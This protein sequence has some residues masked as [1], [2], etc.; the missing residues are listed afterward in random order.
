MPNSKM[1]EVENK[2]SGLVDA[3]IK[4]DPPLPHAYFD[5]DNTVGCLFLLLSYVLLMWDVRWSGRLIVNVSELK[6]NLLLLI[7][8]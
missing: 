1:P 3:D 4:A 8:D 7:S 2:L 6:V 5:F